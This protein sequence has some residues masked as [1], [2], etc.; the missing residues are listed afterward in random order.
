MIR[1]GECGATPINPGLSTKAYEKDCLVPMIKH[2][3]GAI[4]VSA[5]PIITLKGRVTASDNVK[6]LASHVNPMVQTLFPQR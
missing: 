4:M 1:R 5:G 2:G 3:G 6:I